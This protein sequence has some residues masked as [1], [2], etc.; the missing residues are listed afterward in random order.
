ML[1][2]LFSSHA[3]KL[4]PA[5]GRD[6]PRL[7]VRRLIIWKGPNDIVRDIPLRPGLNVI[8]SPDDGSRSGRI[9]HGGG[10]TT[11]CRLIRYCLGEDSFGPEH[12]RRA[13]FE[14]MPTGMVGAEVRLDGE[15]WLIR[16]AFHPFKD[17]FAFLA[18]SFSD[19]ETFPS[20][21]TGMAPFRNAATEAFLADAL[22]LMP[23]S[24]G[25]DDAWLALLAW[26]S[27]D[28]ECRFGHLF[29]WRSP[30][31]GSH[32]PVSGRSRPQED[33]EAVVRIILDALRTAE[34]ETRRQWEA[35]NSEISRQRA[36][37][38]RLIWRIGDLRGRLTKAL[39]LDG[40]NASRLDAAIIKSAAADQL[41]KAQGLASPVTLEQFQTAQRQADQDATEEAQAKSAVE[42]ATAR[43]K[44][45]EQLARM[46]ADQLPELS[47]QNQRLANPICPICDVP[48][49]KARADGCGI[50][51]HPAD[52]DS[53]RTNVNNLKADCEKA[54]AEA[55]RWKSELP[56]LQ[57]KWALAKQATERHREGIKKIGQAIFAYTQDIKRAERIW[58][59]AIDFEES[60]AEL[61]TAEHSLA[62]AE[63][64][65]KALTS[66]LETHR[67]AAITSVGELSDRFDGA[68]HEIVPGNA[69]CSIKLDGHGLGVRV[70]VDGAAIDSLK[71]TV[72]DLA[73]LSM[74][75]EGKTRHPGFLIHDSPREADLGASIYAGIFDLAKKLEGFGPA[76]LFQYIVTTT[77]EPPAGFQSAPW[78][79]LRLRSSPPDERLLR[80]DI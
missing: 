7:W 22:T 21:P 29:D 44:D 45:Q 79:R 39:G 64:R 56:I 59:W 3:L 32:S 76:P 54:R 1:P 75:I 71:V 15:T 55:A 42:L 28:Q 4:A 73:A 18:S 25:Q 2:D 67:S 50:S 70:P 49:D 69:R 41:A 12:R 6:E 77:T 80:E 33:R 13:V 40:G 38:D 43:E 78:L 74:A 8:W 46:I 58:G 66:E 16:R 61:A 20:E 9:G 36:Q 37:R 23:P 26:L 31:S 48:I 19:I 27:R 30:E 62:A 5:P 10:K 51:L 11:F 72:F 14:K 57:G 47:A 34:I 24:I 17:D 63:D 60:D 52:L 35:T 68:F 53:L 65:L